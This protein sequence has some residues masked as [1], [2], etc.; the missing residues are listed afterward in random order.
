MS[1]LGVSFADV[2]TAADELVQAGEQPTIEKIRY[3]LGSH[4]SFSTISRFLK[5]WREGR[6]VPK[7]MSV[8]PPDQV[9]AAV[10][11]VWEKLHQETQATIEAVK[12]EAKDQVEAAREEAETANTALSTLKAE[13]ETLK[14]QHHAL[15]AQKELLALD[16]K[17]GE[18]NQQ[19]LR[20]RLEALESR[21][22][23]IKSMHEQQLKRLEEKYL[24]EIER[25]KS[26]A[27]QEV[28]LSRQLADALKSHYEDARVD[29]MRQLDQLK[30]ENQKSYDA[31][32][33][34]EADNAGLKQ[35]LEEKIAMH[36]QVT[37]QLT[38]AQ[39]LIQTQQT[40]WDVLQDK[41]FVTE[42]IVAAFKTLP[43]QVASELHTLLTE[44][45]KE[46]MDQA[47]KTIH[48]KLKEIDHA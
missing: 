1:R 10:S 36:Q 29:S 20:E 27:E 3:Q 31:I 21:H 5:D 40:Q 33:R 22:Q 8:T 6:L 30:V 26:Y 18:A 13:H 12:A 2:A 15:L 9:Q 19:L 46:V 11:A 23:E 7:P 44:Q 45:V 37:A 17:Q 14:T 16:Y 34:L 47:A 39:K 24:A 48:I 28:Q 43:V 32:K 38:E 42:E 35:S 4:G 25:L 41:R